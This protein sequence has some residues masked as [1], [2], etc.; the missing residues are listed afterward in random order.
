M[1]FNNVSDAI[2]LVFDTLKDDP[3]SVEII[4]LI[5]TA[6]GDEAIKDGLRKAVKRL[7]VV[8]LAV[9]KT[10]QEKAKGFAF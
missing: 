1:N 10:V 8:N 4:E 5:D 6:E 2:M 9:S 7:D 3:E